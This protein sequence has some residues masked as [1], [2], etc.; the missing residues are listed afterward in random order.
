[1]RL[2]G[3]SS[4]LIALCCLSSLVG[5]VVAVKAS[6]VPPLGTVLNPPLVLVSSVD[7][8]PPALGPGLVFYFYH[9][10][11]LQTYVRGSLLMSLDSKVPISRHVRIPEHPSQQHALL[12]VVAALHTC[13]RLLFGF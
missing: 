8:S 4:F 13:R 2:A 9:T 7:E 5:L 6:F 11:S 12:L 3:A 10:L 1:M